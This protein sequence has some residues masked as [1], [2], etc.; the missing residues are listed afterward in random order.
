MDDQLNFQTYLFISPKKFVILVNTESNDKLYEK[1][2]ISK[3]DY[4]NY[5]NQLIENMLNQETKSTLS[6][7]AVSSIQKTN[8]TQSS[9]Q[10]QLPKINV[11]TIPSTDQRCLP[12]IDTRFP[13]YTGC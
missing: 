13:I 2:L 8:K 3:D 11:S 12:V 5:K 6:K 4:E 10:N 7:P 1:E 9:Q